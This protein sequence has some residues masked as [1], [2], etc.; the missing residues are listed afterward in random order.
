MII[1]PGIYM[2]F[3][4]FVR[5]MV[6]MSHQQSGFA[7]FGVRVANK[8]ANFMGNF[9]FNRP[10][11]TTAGNPVAINN[12]LLSVS[13]LKFLIDTNYVFPEITEI[14]FQIAHT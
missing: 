13:R 8:R 5:P 11:Q 10:V 1:R 6:G 12:F 14:V 9:F 3:N 7:G 4:D 2:L